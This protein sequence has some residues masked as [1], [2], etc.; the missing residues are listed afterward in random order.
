MSVPI[1]A[2]MRSAVMVEMPGDRGEQIT[3]GDYVARLVVRVLA[4]QAALDT[5]VKQVDLCGVAVDQ[6]E[7][8]PSQEPVVGAK[9][10]C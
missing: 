5:F 9:P 10:A 4:G 8:D 2:M 6:V 3:A 7:V 1:S